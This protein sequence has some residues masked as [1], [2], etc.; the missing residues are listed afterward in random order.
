MEEIACI[1]GSEFLI[2]KQFFAGLHWIPYSKTTVPGL[3]LCEAHL[4][5]ETL[6]GS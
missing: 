5:F 2:F 6:A 3:D 1:E 4:N